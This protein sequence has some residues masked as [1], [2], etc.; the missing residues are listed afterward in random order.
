MSVR[1][2]PGKANIV[3]DS[4]SRLSMGSV[5]HVEE[6]RKELVKD[7]HRLTQLGV[8]LMSISESGVTVQNGEESSLVVEVK[9]KQKSD[10]I[11]LELKGTVHNQ[12]VEVFS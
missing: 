7:V 10:P 2:H 12:R 9:E 5:A 3:V 6:Q 8:C 11:L 1:Y 4:L